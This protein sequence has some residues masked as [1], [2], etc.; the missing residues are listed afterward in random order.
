MILRQ[1]R[2]RTKRITIREGVCAAVRLLRGSG[3]VKSQTGLGA[4]L[5]EIGVAKFEGCEGYGLH[6]GGGVFDGVHDSE[7]GDF[8]VAG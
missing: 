5:G 6:V 1:W 7:G 2:R 3:L 8:G 4:A